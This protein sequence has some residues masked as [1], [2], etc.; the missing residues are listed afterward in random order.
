NTL[1]TGEEVRRVFVDSPHEV[2]GFFAGLAEAGI[3]AVP[4]L[5]ARAMPYG[6]ITPETYNTLLDMLWRGLAAAGPL[7]GLLVAPHGATV[8]VE[9]RDA[10]GYWLSEL[11]RRVGSQMPIIGTLDPH[12]NLSPR[13]VAACDALTAYRSNPHL[14]QRARGIEAAR[15]M[16]RTLRGEIK[17]TMAAAFPRVAINIER[18]LTSEPHC[19]ALYQQADTQLARPGVLSNSVILGFPYADVEEMG[20]ALIV[21]TDNDAALAQSLANELGDWLWA[22]REQFAGQLISIDQALD[23]SV[24]LSGPVCLLDMGDN[25]G[26]GSPGDSTFLAHAI[27]ERRLPRSLVCLYD[28]AAVKAA[29]AAGPDARVRLAVGGKTDD[30]HGRP[31]EAEFTVVSLHDGKFFEPQPRHGGFTQCDQGPTAVVRTDEGLTVVLTSLR[32]P[33]FSLGQLTSCGLEPRD[34]HL[35]VAKGVNAPVA[36]YAPICSDLIRVNTPGVTTA[37]MESLEYRHRRKPMFPFERGS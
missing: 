3:E 22:H 31:L 35:L 6:P 8:A 5:A 23:R 30:R 21:V 10:D 32:M 2:G 29:T 15:L 14:D 9:H 27:H 36:A 24:K 33:P 1:A 4:I 13:M 37:D 34:Y 28:P 19:V 18:Q 7:D 17:P 25:V 11:R 16:A 12:A 20:S 26:G